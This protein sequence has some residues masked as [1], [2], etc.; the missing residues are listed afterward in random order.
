MFYISDPPAHAAQPLHSRSPLPGNGAG[1]PL[2]GQDLLCKEHLQLGIGFILLRN[3]RR[4]QVSSP[5]VICDQLVAAWILLRC[6]DGYNSPWIEDAWPCE[7]LYSGQ[8]IEYQILAGPVFV[9]VGTVSALVFGALS[10]KFN[11]L[12]WEK[13]QGASRFMHGERTFRLFIDLQ[14]SFVGHCNFSRFDMWHADGDSPRV[15]APCTSQ[16]D[17]LQRVRK[18]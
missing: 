9:V 10:D 17:Y 11:R 18:N 13:Q 3:F 14:A 2:R 8:G 12:K 16:D 5:Y 4:R 15:L 7:Y 1:H 6:R